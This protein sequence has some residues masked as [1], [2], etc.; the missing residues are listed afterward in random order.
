MMIA[1]SNTAMAPQPAPPDPTIR[2][3]D[4]A[5]A[6]E[7]AFLAEMLGA[8]GLGKP[9]DGFSGG[10]GEEQFASFLTQ[11]K[12]Q[13]IAARGGIGLQPAILASLQGRHHE[14]G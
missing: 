14:H 3:R 12:A 11:A 8:A 10:V 2:L 4:T 7:A 9:S 13:A 6:F 5:R 1:L